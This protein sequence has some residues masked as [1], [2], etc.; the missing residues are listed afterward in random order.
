[1]KKGFFFGIMAAVLLVMGAGIACAGS[2]YDPRIDRRELRQERRIERGI[3]S[4]RLTPW[5][6]RALGRQQAHIRHMEARMKADG[7]LTFRERRRLHHRLNVASRDIWRMN[8]NCY[9][10]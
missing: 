9:Y 10:R 4:G 5:E 1:M 7:H 6:A 8:H 2:T 3:A